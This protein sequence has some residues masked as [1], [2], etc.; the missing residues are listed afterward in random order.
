MLGV[1]R[2]AACIDTLL[3]RRPRLS[4]A[5]LC[6]LSQA[7]GSI[8]NVIGADEAFPVALSV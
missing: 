3:P 1:V 8:L 5:L 4:I 6:Q 7:Y 2:S